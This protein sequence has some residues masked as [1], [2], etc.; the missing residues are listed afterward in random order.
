MSSIEN[1]INKFDKPHLPVPLYD[2]ERKTD[3]FNA[4]L[5]LDTHEILQCNLMYKIPF[6]I[7]D[8]NR[9]S[10]IHILINNPSKSSELAKLSV[11]KFLI[12]NG[13]DPD[14]PNKYNQTALHLACKQQLEKIVEYLLKNYVDPNYKDNSGFT[15]FHYLLSGSINPVPLTE[16]KDFIP[17]TNNVNFAKVEFIKNMKE[18]INNLLEE[19]KALPIFQTIQ[20]T[21]IAFIEHDAKVKKIIYEFRQ[22]QLAKLKEDD[23]F[24]LAEDISQSIKLFET[25]IDQIIRKQFQI[26]P[27]TE[28]IIHETTPTSWKYSSNN[29]NPIEYA[30]ITDGDIRASIRKNIKAQ[31]NELIQLINNFNLQLY[32]TDFTTNNMNIYNIIY[33]ELYITPINSSIKLYLLGRNRPDSRKLSHFRDSD[34]GQQS[35][36]EDRY[37]SNPDIKR[38]FEE[39]DTKLRYKTASDNA[40]SIINFKTL[41][42]TGGPR[43]ICLGNNQKY[44]A[45]EYIYTEINEILKKL[46]ASDT[47]DIYLIN[48]M[49][50]E[51][52]IDSISNGTELYNNDREPRVVLLE[53]HKQIIIDNMN[54]YIKLSSSAILYK[55]NNSTELNIDNFPGITEFGKKWFNKWESRKD[56]DVGAWIFNMWTDC[57]CRTSRSNLIGFVDF[58]LLLLI[59]NLNNLNNLT[60]IRLHIFNSLKPH[61]ISYLIESLPH[62]GFDDTY[63]VI[64]NNIIIILLFDSNDINDLQTIINN[65]NIVDNDYSNK[66][67]NSNMLIIIDL[68]VRYFTNELYDSTNKAE[69]DEQIKTQM[70]NTNSIDLKKYYKYDTIIDI[71][72]NMIF[73]EYKNMN[74]KPLKQTILDFLYLLNEYNTNFDINIFSS[75]SIISK[76]NYASHKVSSIITSKYIMMPSYYGYMNVIN[77]EFTIPNPNPSNDKEDIYNNILHRHFIIAHILGLYYEGTLNIISKNDFINT[78][79]KTNNAQN[80]IP[81]EKFSNSDTHAD[82]TKNWQHKTHETTNEFRKYQVPLVLQF[83]YINTQDFDEDNQ[84]FIIDIKKQCDNDIDAVNKNI[85]EFEQ[86]KNTIQTLSIDN[87]AEF[88]NFLTNKMAECIQLY[89]DVLNRISTPVDI[90]K[91]YNITLITPYVNALNQIKTDIERLITN[92]NNRIS[93]LVSGTNV[94]NFINTN[95]ITIKTGVNTAIQNMNLFF[96][97]ILN[98]Y[99]AFSPAKYNYNQYAELYNIWDRPIILPTTISYFIFLYNK[100]RYYQTEI[101]TRYQEIQTEIR[102]F[103]TGQAANSKDAYGLKYFE[104]IILSKII[105]N[106]YKSFKEMDTDLF[107][108]NYPKIGQWINKISEITS[109]KKKFKLSNPP[110][111]DEEIAKILNKI[112]SSYYIY[113][114]IF[115]NN[116][117]IK[118]NKFNYYQLPSKDEAIKYLYFNGLGNMFDINEEPV[119]SL[120]A[121]FSD[122]LTNIKHIQNN[123]G[124]F[125][126]YDI[127]DYTT[128]YEKYINIPYLYLNNKD[129]PDIQTPFVINKEGDLPPSVYVNF[130]DFYKYTTIFLIQ[131]IIKGGA[132]GAFLEESK[133]YIKQYIKPPDKMI[134]I[135]AY[136]LI[137]KIIEQLI[138]NRY[139]IS[140]KDQIIVKKL[141]IMKGGATGPFADGITNFEYLLS[142]LEKQY[143]SITLDTSNQSVSS[144]QD[145]SNLYNLVIPPSAAP[146][147]EKPFILYPN[148]LTNINKFKIKNGITIKSKIIELLIDGGG[149]PYHLNMENSTPIDYLLKNYQ[150]KTIKRVYSI[151]QKYKINYNSK[152]SIKYTTD[153][154]NNMLGKIIYN[155]ETIE[156]KSILSNFH[157]YLYEDIHQ[158][159]MTNNIYGNNEF[160]SIPISFNISTYLT[161]HYLKCTLDTDTNEVIYLYTQMKEL[162]IY[163]KTNSLIAKDI[164][165]KKT[166]LL[167]NLQSYLSKLQEITSPS[168]LESAQI[169]KLNTDIKTMET[170]IKHIKT[171]IL[172]NRGMFENENIRYD[173]DNLIDKYKEYRYNT[174]AS[175][176]S[177]KVWEE[178]FNKSNTL[179]TIQTNNDMK[180]INLIIQQ[181]QQINNLDE[182]KNISD[183]LKKIST[184]SEEYFLK[185]KFTDK[186]KTASFIKNM[187]LYVGKITFETS[188]YLLVKHI[189]FKYFSQMYKDTDKINKTIRNILEFNVDKSGKTFIDTLK[190]TIEDLVTLASNIYENKDDEMKYEMNSSRQV[191]LNLF[192]YLKN[193]DITLSEEILNIFDK[194]VVEYLDTFIVKTI[195]MWHVNA[196]NIFKYFINNYRCL[197]TLICLLEHK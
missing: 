111:Y 99:K 190:E 79:V 69:Y 37:N 14:K 116:V 39:Q 55:L 149:N 86:I 44:N 162:N 192:A 41:K 140:I 87:L 54:D 24:F 2:L 143:I 80:F 182:L 197:A 42:Y 72:C 132:I 191:L 18:T 27:L 115:Q 147:D 11:I 112:N 23:G 123:R 175:L 142:N 181:K 95:R 38:L 48:Y 97:E 195:E 7:S 156:L 155:V 171:I 90:I 168:K 17:P 85:E 160:I 137:S 189:L 78:L 130:D 178:F 10:L 152:N 107:S 65:I 131:Q 45:K 98:I 136:Y 64:L 70:R 183:K 25:N 67:L 19:I 135:Y 179:N 127:T 20:N 46:Y 12:N 139:D 57:S 163:K 108:I 124:L 194:Q 26:R 63:V 170:E 185:P 161:L 114:Y 94:Q 148:D 34:I 174:A 51:E 28:L 36:P 21:I 4:V 157:M 76:I 145:L 158:L 166:E 188:I 50:G 5:S 126:I 120:D 91:Y 35:V 32:K 74:N 73:D 187:L 154:L 186:N 151:L 133:E 40:S 33:D 159:I 58:K 16:I 22:A 47:S 129:G 106:Y 141:Q 104:I 29:T 138:I 164:L 103:I 165:S 167:T 30:F 134:E 60:D 61:L 49:L 71:L 53:P 8:D 110:I 193:G 9:N 153:E 128:T 13:V 31:N 82:P 66:H 59:N 100:I 146:N 144:V 84:Q 3:M 6:T 101:K 81:G 105:N 102:H 68:I 77:S 125:N 88:N 173:I 122:G 177:L 96:N 1:K 150:N 184:V 62:S 109:D 119:K 43:D 196:E 83:T 56:F 93:T 180:L 118:L 89:T 172:K 75:I 15:P 52:Y 169:I 92:Y 176:K 117:Q 113:H 121:G